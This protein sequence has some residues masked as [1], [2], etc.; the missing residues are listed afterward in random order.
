MP[1]LPSCCRQGWTFLLL[2]RRTVTYSLQAT[3]KARTHAPC[4]HDANNRQ[5]DATNNARST[6]ASGAAKD[7]TNNARSTPASGAAKLP[8]AVTAGQTRQGV[9]SVLSLEVCTRFK[10]FTALC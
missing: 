9:R 4:T 2:P 5:E 8:F 6:P 7:A 1:L 10:V 3:Y